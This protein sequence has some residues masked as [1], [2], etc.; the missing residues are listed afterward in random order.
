M[1][2]INYYIKTLTAAGGKLLPV[3]V[4]LL[5][6]YFL[7]IKLPFYFMVKVNKENKPKED[8]LKD[9]AV[10]HKTAE[11]EKI[12][13]FEDDF[14][15]QAQILDRITKI[16]EVLKNNSTILYNEI[17][18]AK[19][20]FLNIRL[21]EKQKG[22]LE[23][24]QNSLKIIYD[25]FIKKQKEGLENFITTFSG[26]INEFYQ[27]MNPN[28]PFQELKI[29]TIGE[30]DELNGLTIEYK[31]EGN[32]VS[33]P[34]KYFSESHLNCFGLSFFQLIYIMSLYH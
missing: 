11:P 26:K 10:E 30:D 12:N 23:N 3:G 25:E 1:D 6:G 27:F 20:A 15:F 18:S 34:Q 16:K 22:V 21:I 7:F 19:E 28:E 29:V 31:Y 32:W 5:V 4:F 9:V 2:I 24:Q 8:G 33:P 13:I 17:S 14:N